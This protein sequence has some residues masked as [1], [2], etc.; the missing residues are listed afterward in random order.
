M[1]TETHTYLRF[2]MSDIMYTN[3]IR[4]MPEKDL[5]NYL[6]IAL[7]QA[8]FDL[9]REVKVVATLPGFDCVLSQERSPALA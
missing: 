1:Q 2:T 3:P 5:G 8:G 7:R 6:R 9:T 4:F